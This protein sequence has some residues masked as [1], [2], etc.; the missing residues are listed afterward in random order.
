MWAPLDPAMSSASVFTPVMHFADTELGTRARARGAVVIF[1]GSH[2]TLYPDEAL[3]LGGA[4]AEWSRVTATS[5]GRSY[6][7]MRRAVL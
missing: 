1:G 3:S 5:S 6:S 2:A 4:H 7:A